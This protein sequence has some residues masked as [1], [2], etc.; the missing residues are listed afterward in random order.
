MILQKMFTQKTGNDKTGVIDVYSSCVNHF[1][2]SAGSVLETGTNSNSENEM[3]TYV[4]F[5]QEH[6]HKVNG[7]IFDKDCVAVIESPSAKRGREIAFELFGPKFCF[8]Y[9][10]KHFNMENMHF[11]PRGFIKA[12]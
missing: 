6:I 4:T 5:G 9:P 8:E 12:N 3:K 1:E 10:E 2:R 7:K 11:F